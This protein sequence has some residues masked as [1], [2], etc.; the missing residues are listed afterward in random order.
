MTPRRN[1]AR[2]L[3]KGGVIISILLHIA[4]TLAFLI[5]GFIYGIAYIFAVVAGATISGIAGA[6]YD[7]SSVDF[8]PGP[9]IAITLLFVFAILSFIGL[10]ISIVNINLINKT[11]KKGGLIACG[12]LGIIAGIPT[13]IIP[14]ELIGGIIALTLKDKDACEEAVIEPVQIPKE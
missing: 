6:E 11:S 9:K 12:I 5:V 7:S 13:F 4:Y 3:L 14:L 8:G 2:K 1:K 10:I